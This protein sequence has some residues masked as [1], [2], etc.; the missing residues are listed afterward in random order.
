M[1]DLLDL[2]GIS[3]AVYR[4]QLIRDEAKIPAEGGNY[5]YVRRSDDAV[6]VVYCGV[7]DTLHDSRAH[8]SRAVGEF[9]ANA[10]YVR[11]NITRSQREREHDDIV[12]AA[13]PSM[14]GSV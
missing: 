11:R 10:I 2:K 9:G 5:V 4:F 14:Q 6:S 3:G 1:K 8:W 12:A 7:S 13:K